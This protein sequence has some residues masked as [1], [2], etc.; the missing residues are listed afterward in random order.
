MHDL[1][2][3]WLT[4]MNIMTNTCTLWYIVITQ[5]P[6]PP[7]FFSLSVVWVTIQILPVIRELFLKQ[8]PSL[9]IPAFQVRG[10][11]GP[12]T[13]RGVLSTHLPPSHPHCNSHS[14]H[15]E[16]VAVFLLNAPQ[17]AAHSLSFFKTYHHESPPL[18]LVLHTVQSTCRNKVEHTVV[19]QDIQHR[20]GHCSRQY[21]FIL[22][23]IGSVFPHC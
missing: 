18:K 9:F 7:C 2:G 23:Y 22:L 4:P 5:W 6:E 12:N 13:H 14:P 20:D 19:V 16:P 1:K 3:S 8:P 21:W 15:T 10:N 11:V 17:S